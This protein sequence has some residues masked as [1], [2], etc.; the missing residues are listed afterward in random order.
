MKYDLTIKTPKGE[1][2]LL[3]KYLFRAFGCEINLHKIVRGDDVGCFHTHPARALRIVLWGGYVEQRGDGS[4]VFW[5][6]GKWGIITPEF[7]HRIAYLYGKASYTLWFRGHVTAEIK[8]RG[9]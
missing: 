4:M 5:D 9:C 8:T 3:I 7:E 1:P 6:P 2:V